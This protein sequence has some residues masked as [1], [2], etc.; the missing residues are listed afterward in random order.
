MLIECPSTRC[1]ETADLAVK[2]VFAILGVDIDH[3]ESVENFRED[4]RF[5]SKLRRAADNSIIVLAGM[6]VA[7]IGSLVWYGI[8]HSIGG[9]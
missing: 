7:M 9:K 5:G 3:P 1:Q 4:L 6:V 2:K 8:M